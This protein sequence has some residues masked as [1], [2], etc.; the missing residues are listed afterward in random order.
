MLWAARH[1]LDNGTLTEHTN[2]NL[3]LS[4]SMPAVRPRT[5]G[6]RVR[7]GLYLGKI[8]ES[9]PSVQEG[10]ADRLGLECILDLLRMPWSGMKAS[11]RS[12]MR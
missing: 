12:V 6:L 1:M 2:V 11:S 3:A 5:R 10:V 8:E 7:F 4:T 9:D